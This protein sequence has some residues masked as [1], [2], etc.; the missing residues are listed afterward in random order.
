MSA[1]HIYSG[2]DTSNVSVHARELRAPLQTIVG[3]FF[4]FR[5]CIVYL[6]FQSDP[7]TGSV[8]NIA[9]IGL[10]FVAALVYTLG[11]DR[12]S[13]HDLF[14]N[15]ILRWLFAYLAVTALSLLWTAA[16]SITDATVQWA[17]MVMEVGTILLLIK[18]PNVEFN[19]DALMRGFV[20]GML[21]VDAVAWLSPVTADLRIGNEDFLHPNAVGLYSALAFFLA[22]QLSL[23]HRAWRW[24]CLALGITLLRSISKTSII[25]FLIAE[26]FYLSRE[27]QIARRA[28]IKMA[29]VAALVVVFFGA[30]LRANLEAYVSAGGINQ[31]ESLTGRTAIWALVFPAA[32]EHPWLGSG[33]YSFRALIPDLGGYQARHAHN[34]LL[35]QFF[36]LG[37]L[38]VFVS[39]GL[40]V[41]FFLAARRDVQSPYRRLIFTI[42]VFVMVHGLT[43]T[44]S[45]GFTVPLWIFASMAI[46]LQ[47]PKEL[48]S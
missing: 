20:T 38:G 23:K 15:R 47:Q 21:F 36:E 39:V 14:A 35:Q 10:L 45:F 19:V 6:G 42:L 29:A 48:A 46:A 44:V 26:S 43:E 16:T 32:M 27:K 17:G 8:V 30:L 2:T 18:K 7:R 31:A 22:Q 13:L 24:C 1:A 33:F 41:S 3:F 37:L 28:K 12:F 25:A 11:D 4:A 9:C 34:E 40:Y 5:M